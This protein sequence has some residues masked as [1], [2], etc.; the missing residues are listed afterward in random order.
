VNTQ[1][2]TG[3]GCSV[4]WSR[5]RPCAWSADQLLPRRWRGHLR[6]PL[7]LRSTANIGASLSGSLWDRL[8]TSVLTKLS[9]HRREPPSQVL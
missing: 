3:H 2:I 9:C 7:E 8:A 4:S 1:Y 5:L 6:L